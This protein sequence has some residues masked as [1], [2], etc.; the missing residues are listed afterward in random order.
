[1][2]KRVNFKFKSTFKKKKTCTVQNT[3]LFN[4]LRNHVLIKIYIAIH[5]KTTIQQQSENRDLRKRLNTRTSTKY[6]RGSSES[7]TTLIFR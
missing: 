7:I 5:L 6:D 1:M 2:R 3:Y 4:K